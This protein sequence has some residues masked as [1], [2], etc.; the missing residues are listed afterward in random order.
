[1]KKYRNFLSFAFICMALTGCYDD[2]EPI[3]GASHLNGG[4][5]DGGVF[6]IQDGDTIDLMDQVMYLPQGEKVI[7]F[8][9]YYPG[10]DFPEFDDDFRVDFFSYQPDDILVTMTDADEAYSESWNPVKCKKVSADLVARLF[11]KCPIRKRHLR[12]EYLTDAPPVSTTGFLVEV[13]FFQFRLT[14]YW[15]SS[16]KIFQERPSEY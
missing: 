2:P 10:P 6:M 1:M 4:S 11:G 5:M 16:F 13:N 9:I 15:W 14:M 7:E 12:V 3:E 8:D